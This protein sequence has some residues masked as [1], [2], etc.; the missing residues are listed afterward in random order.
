MLFFFV[1]LVSLLASWLFGFFLGFA[2]LC[3]FWWLWL[4]ASS[5][6]PVPLRF[7][8]FWLW[9]PASSAL[10]VPSYLNHHFFKH[11]GGAAQPPAT[12]WIVRKDLIA[13]LF[14]S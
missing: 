14:E 2:G 10:S 6:F 11:H 1:F 12:F 4:F 7:I 5:A 9:L 8:G 3:S 13:P